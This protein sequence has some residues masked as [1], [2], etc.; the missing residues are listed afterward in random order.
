MDLLKQLTIKNEPVDIVST[1]KYLGVTVDNQLNWQTQSALTFKK[2]NQLLFFDEKIMFFFNID[3]KI[4][5][6]FL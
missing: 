2:M 4:L 5:S 1:I 3:T 6:L